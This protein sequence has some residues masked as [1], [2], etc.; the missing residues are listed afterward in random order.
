MIQVI[1]YLRFSY[2]GRSDARMTRD[3]DLDQLRA[4]LY[5]PDRMNQR[6]HFFENICLPS[7]DAQTDQDFKMMVLIGHDMP[8]DQRK[9]LDDLIEGRPYIELI[10]DASMLMAQAFNRRTRHIKD[11]KATKIVHFRL[12]DDDALSS[13]FVANLR[14]MGTRAENPTILSMS[15]GVMLTEIDNKV[16][17]V[18]EVTPFIAIG[19]ALVLDPET[20]RNP[21]QAAH[22]RAAR[23]TPSMLD[24]RH[25]SYVHTIHPGS[26]SVQGQE[27]NI[28]AYLQRYGR[29]QD[30]PNYLRM[31]ASLE[32][33]FPC[34]TESY[35]RDVRA[36]MP[37]GPVYDLSTLP[38]DAP[39]VPT[40][41]GKN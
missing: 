18:E 1:G 32:R 16:H 37:Q 35:L 39:G 28:R 11:P 9:R 30:H 23:N 4:R 24:P 19:W 38:N 27:R 20:Q 10:V 14:A 12:D 8:Q 3:P 15:R 17:L 6:F 7:L 33:E 34:F 31:I 41:A 29:T 2:P 21:F 26:D 5:H 36:T 22:V 40:A 13:H 25:L